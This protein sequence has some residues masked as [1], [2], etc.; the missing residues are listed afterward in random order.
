[1]GGALDTMPVVVVVD[2]A[3]CLKRK[4]A[5]YIT[6]SGSKVTRGRWKLT[7]CLAAA[8]ACSLS[9]M[10]YKV[11]EIREDVDAAVSG[12]YCLRNRRKRTRLVM[13]GRTKE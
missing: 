2:G 12:R 7:R 11:T 10:L 8:I 9:S 4:F 5:I 1:V 13:T 3:G 6:K